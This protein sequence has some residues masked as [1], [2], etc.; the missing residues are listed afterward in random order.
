MNTDEKIN[1]LKEE[2]TRRN[3]ENRIQL[4]SG[5]LPKITLTLE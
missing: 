5:S 1:E 2:E 4:N 3:A